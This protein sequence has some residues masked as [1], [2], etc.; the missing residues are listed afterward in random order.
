MVASAK[1][2]TQPAAAKAKIKKAASKTAKGTKATEAKPSVAKATVVKNAKKSVDLKPAVKKSVDGKPAVKKS[3]PVEAAFVTTGGAK[4]AK[5]TD[6]VREKVGV[7]KV[8][9]GKTVA[10]VKERPKK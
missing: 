6:A 1:L 10:K 2:D 7:A 3:A 9:A 5:A 4:R 8:T